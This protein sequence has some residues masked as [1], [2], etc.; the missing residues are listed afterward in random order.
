MK[1][2]Y[3]NSDIYEEIMRHALESYPHEGCGVLVGT[4]NRVLKMYH[5]DNLNK[6]R[7][8]DRYKID[9]RAILR[10]EKTASNEGLDIVGFYHSH[11]DHPDRPSTF[12]RERAWPDYIYIIVSVCNGS[13][14]S[15]KAWTI[16]T[17]DEPFS[18]RKMIK[19][20]K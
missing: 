3:L 12:D 2:I 16:N 9:P 11:P 17:F 18:E 10:I 5:V 8:K 20:E 1:Q 6:E 15:A 19:E 4:K 7:A 14:T 13:E